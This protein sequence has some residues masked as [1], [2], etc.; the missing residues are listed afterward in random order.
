MRIFLKLIL[1]SLIFIGLLIGIELCFVSYAKAQEFKEEKCASIQVKACS[2]LSER[3]I[4]GVAVSQCWNY[5]EKFYCLT[6]ERNNCAA[7]EENRGCQE[8]AANCLEKSDYGLGVCKIQEK[9]FSCGQK[10]EE[11]AEIKHIDTQ[12]SVLKDEKELSGCLKEDQD[13]YCEEVEEVCIE[14]KET[15]N[16]NGKDIYKDCWKWEK[17]YACRKNTFIDECASLPKNCQLTGKKECLHSLSVNGKQEC[18]H[19]ELKYQCE[20]NHTY[21]KECLN[22]Q[23]CLG[24]VCEKTA[25]TQ[26]NDFASSISGL[27]VLTSL[28]SDAIDGCKCPNGKQSCEP[29]EIDTSSCKLFT[30][31]SNQC[32]KSTAQQNCCS[33]KGF[34]R[35]V[36]GC[37]QNE[38]DL[39]VKRVAGLCHHIGSWSG[40]SIKDKL[41]FTSY[42]SH[43]CFKSRLAK[44]IQVQGRSQL[45]I[46]WGDSKNPDCRALSLEEVQ[47]IDFNKIDFSELFHEMGSKAR[48][49]GVQAQDKIKAGIQSTQGNPQAESEL[50]KQKINRFYSKTTNQNSENGGAK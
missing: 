2:D 27:S 50:I 13:K 38:K 46:S 49:G 44:I 23:V 31:H 43:C 41:T 4:D 42:Q 25:R 32:H 20:E 19:Y 3:I 47:K 24:G 10:I 18:D 22:S 12:F 6:R 40:K 7:L 36:I 37:S 35:S 30:G 29:G 33:N 45:G 21:K 1:I 48:R 26:H 15:R 28:K 5:Q 11:K 14:P 16:I 9:K 17:K 8:I 39:M 34:I